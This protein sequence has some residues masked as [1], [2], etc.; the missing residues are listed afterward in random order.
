ML[1][2][3]LQSAFNNQINAEI[4]SSYLYY[5]IANFYEE[6]GLLIGLKLKLKKN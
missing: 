6:K 2:E 5:S 4:Y 1:S 3:N